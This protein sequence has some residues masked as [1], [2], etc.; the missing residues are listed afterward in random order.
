M[1]KITGEPGHQGF[2]G[3]C[4]ELFYNLSKNFKALLL[5]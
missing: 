4:K 1:V 5:S 3:S 2:Q